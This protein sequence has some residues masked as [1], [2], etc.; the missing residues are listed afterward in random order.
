MAAGLNS[1]HGVSRVLHTHMVRGR[2][3]GKRGRFLPQLSGFLRPERWHAI[4]QIADALL[5]L[6]VTI[7]GFVRCRDL[8]KP[9]AQ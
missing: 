8:K 4:A 5:A 7:G 2:C 6:K 3:D 1:L 9:G